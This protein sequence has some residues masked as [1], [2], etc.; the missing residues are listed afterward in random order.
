M[1]K[2][3]DIPVKLDIPLLKYSCSLCILLGGYRVLSLPH[4]ENSAP[5]MSFPKAVLMWYY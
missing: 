4:T 2:L 5:L 3:S 1:V